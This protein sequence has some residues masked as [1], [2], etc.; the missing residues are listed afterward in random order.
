MLHLRKAN[1][2]GVQVGTAPDG[3]TRLRVP[4]GSVPGIFLV[5]LPG[6]G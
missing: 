2:L 6:R 4:L 1:G 3:V 5:E